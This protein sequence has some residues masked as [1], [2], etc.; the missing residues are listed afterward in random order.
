MDNAVRHWHVTLTLCGEAA[1]PLIVRGAMQRLSDERP[2]LDSVV[3]TG[4]SVEIQFWD[5]GENMLDVASL[6]MRLWNEHRES[7]KLPYWE[8]VGLEIVEKNLRDHRGA[9][10]RRA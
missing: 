4:S 3:S 2:F 1:E 7:A 9:L 10:G 5:E 6:A 8:V